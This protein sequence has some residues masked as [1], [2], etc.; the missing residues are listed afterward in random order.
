LAFLIRQISPMLNVNTV[1]AVAGPGDE[2]LV[3]QLGDNIGQ[4]RLISFVG[5]LNFQQI[6]ALAR[7]AVG[8]IGNDTGLTHYAAAVGAATVMILGPTDPARYRPY[9]PN[10]LALWK[11]YAVAAEGA[12]AG[13]PR[14]FDWERDGISP[15]DAAEPVLQFLQG[16]A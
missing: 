1:V 11:P 6:G 14:R 15:A 7:V 9:T 8:Y 10:A 5:S 13:A 4:L 16:R 2:A 12:S 3:R